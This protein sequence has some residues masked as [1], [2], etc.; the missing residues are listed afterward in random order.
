MDSKRDSKEWSRR[1]FLQTVGATVPTLT[2]AMKG[3]DAKGTDRIQ[4]EGTP[5]GKFTPIDLT[6]YF[7]FSE[8][9]R[10]T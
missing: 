5:A 8:R 2:L 1:T 4:S 10:A 9:L 7:N 6:P 3:A